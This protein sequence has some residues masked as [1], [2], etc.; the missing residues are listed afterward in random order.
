MDFLPIFFGLLAAA[1]FGLLIHYQRRGLESCD[2][3]VGAFISVLAMT[4]LLWILSPFFIDYNWI[5][6]KAAFIFFLGGLFFPASAQIAQAFSITKVGPAI[7][8][9][10]GAFAPFFAAVPAVIFLGEVWNAQLVFGMSIMTIGLILAA[11]NTN[12]FKRNWPIWVLLLPLG[13][14]LGR[15]VIQ[16]IVKAGLLENPSPFL[17][18]LILGS[19]SSIMLTVILIITGKY[20]LVGDSFEGFKWFSISGII[21]ALGILSIMYAV[22]LGGVTLAAPLVATSPIWALLFGYVIFRNEILVPRH[23]FVA[24]LVVIGSILIVLR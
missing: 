19:T 6:T 4:T 11:T 23:L 16:P 22:N 7:T 3:L 24:G 8:S 15:G 2:P 1:L 17:A 5:L 9:A 14:S 13:A 18:T 12:T 20:K 10:M 21:N